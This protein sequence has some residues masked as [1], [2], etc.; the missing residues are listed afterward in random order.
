MRNG[1]L[2]T[3]YARGEESLVDEP[4]TVLPGITRNVMFLIAKKLGV[5]TELSQI[6]L[7]DFL[8]AD[9]AFLTNS[10]WGV[11]PVV[12]V[13]ATVRGEGEATADLQQIGDRSVGQFTKD[14][15]NAYWDL[16]EEETTI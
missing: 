15:R 13:A 11:L 7:D 14:F 12:G 5:K 8:A 3:P 1:R 6:S 2:V 16:V 4:S 10:S 9:E